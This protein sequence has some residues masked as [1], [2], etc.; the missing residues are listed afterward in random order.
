MNTTRNSSPFAACSVICVTAPASG[1]I[2]RILPNSDGALVRGTALLGSLLFLIGAGATYHAKDAS[3]RARAYAVEHP[4]MRQLAY[5]DFWY[6]NRAAARLSLRARYD[7]VVIGPPA[8]LY[9]ASAY[10]EEPYKIQLFRTMLRQFG[11]AGILTAE[12]IPW[13]YVFFEEARPSTELLPTV[14]P[15]GSPKKVEG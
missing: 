5:E 7:V 15:R 10:E 6:G 12:E 1:L 8:R 3:A 13:S 9:P 11:L 4:D 14:A 2:L